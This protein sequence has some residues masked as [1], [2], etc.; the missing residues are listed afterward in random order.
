MFGKR[1]GSQ[2]SGRD[3]RTVPVGVMNREPFESTYFAS[4]VRFVDQIENE[5]PG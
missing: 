1:G 5:V 2:F 3:S 4:G